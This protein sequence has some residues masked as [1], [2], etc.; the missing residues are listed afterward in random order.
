MTRAD[1][2][3]PSLSSA[4]AL[5]HANRLLSAGAEQ[6]VELRALGGVAIA[7]CCPSARISPLSRTY[8]DVDLIVAKDDAHEVA[9]VMDRHGFVAEARFNKLHGHTRLLFD[10]PECHVD[11]LVGKFIMCH[12]LELRGR[13][14]VWAE[15]LAPAD[16]LL[17]KL[18]VANLN[19]KD[20]VDIVALLAD[21]PV[22][23]SDVGINLPYMSALLARDWG[24]WQT[25][26]LT[27]ERVGERLDGLDLP[28]SQADS[29]RRGLAEIVRATE[30]TPKTLRWRARARIGQ[31]V[32]WYNDPE[33]IG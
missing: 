11:V 29:V 26:M 4:S 32:L 1:P 30:A 6:G 33:E 25:S 2:L 22:T 5:E 21:H 16:L 27:I 20:L 8:A 13:L 28:A 24:W 31:R 15:T 18:Q 9:R 17:T 19:Q 3:E 7:M 12:E 23:D 10:S 14:T